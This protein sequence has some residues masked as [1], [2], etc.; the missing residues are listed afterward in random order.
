MIPQCAGSLCV[1][2]VVVL[3]LVGFKNILC[4]AIPRSTRGG[5][6]K[7]DCRGKG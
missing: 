2:V 1:G 3:V 4:P 7:M 6:V 5:T